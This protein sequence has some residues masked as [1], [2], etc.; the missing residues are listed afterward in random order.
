[1]SERRAFRRPA[2]QCETPLRSIFDA[3]LLVL[4]DL[5][6]SRQNE[7]RLNNHFVLLHQWGSL[8]DHEGGSFN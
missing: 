4:D 5:F 8:H 1:M 7:S 3:D 2:A 6:L